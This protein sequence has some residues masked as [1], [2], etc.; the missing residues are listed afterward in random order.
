[1]APSGRGPSSLPDRRRRW[2]LSRASA[3]AFFVLALLRVF[4][5]EVDPG[6]QA[7][8]VTGIESAAAF[9][10]WLLIRNRT[11][12]PVTLWHSHKDPT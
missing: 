11:D 3:R 4:G 1:M 8:I 9:L 7:A 10:L 12:G 2:R 6:D 5:Q